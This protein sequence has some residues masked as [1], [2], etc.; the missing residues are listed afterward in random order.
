[1]YTN[2]NMLEILHVIGSQA[3]NCPVSPQQIVVYYFIQI[4]ININN[5]LQAEIYTLEIN[6]TGI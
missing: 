2:Y 4:N 3:R 6:M 5:H 1:M